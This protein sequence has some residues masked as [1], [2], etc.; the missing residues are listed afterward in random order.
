MFAVVSLI[1]IFVSLVITYTLT[2][3]A[4]EYKSNAMA[5]N[6]FTKLI[7]QQDFTTNA[8][9]DPYFWTYT[10][11]PEAWNG[12]KQY[13]TAAN[14]NVSNGT[15]NFVGKRQQMGTLNYSSGKIV[16]RLA[17]KYGRYEVVA[18][19]PKG[20]GTWPAF[21]L[22]DYT[23]N[24][25]GEI[26]VME[27][28]GKIPNWLYSTVHFGTEDATLEHVSEELQ[29]AKAWAGY[30]TYTL[31]WTA[32][33]I[34][35]YIDG[36]TVLTM[37]PIVSRKNGITPLDKPMNVILNLALGGEWGGQISNYIFPSEFKVKSI[38]IWQ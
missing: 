25:Y 7:Y 14:V 16:S 28:V 21:W 33:N 3:K 27:F 9:L 22:F 37:D 15:L 26:D 32:T 34:T 13:Y 17:Y 2:K 19:V 4:T 35:I 8:A 10:T 18:K 5:A 29:I 30:H 12:E 24:G 6:P 36:I 23:N 1:I 31:D 38:K 20:K 11:G